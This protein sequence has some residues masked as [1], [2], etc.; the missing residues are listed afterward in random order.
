MPG[1]ARGSATKTESHARAHT[2][3]HTHRE[4]EMLAWYEEHAVKARHQNFPDLLD[5]LNVVLHTRARAH[6]QERERD[7]E[8]ER[9]RDRERAYG[10]IAGHT[11]HIV[12]VPAPGKRISL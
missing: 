9:Q 8:T 5:N 1:A 11:K 10:D 6:S 12:L 2:H 3:T 4:R 7:R